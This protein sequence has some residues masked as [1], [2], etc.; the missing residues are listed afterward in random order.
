MHCALS[1]G[2]IEGED[3]QG[4]PWAKFLRDILQSIA[5]S[6]DRIT[7]ETSVAIHAPFHLS[8]RL[9]KRPG[10]RSRLPREGVERLRANSLL[11]AG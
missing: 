3:D 6:I 11:N 2:T 4:C 10:S 7:V 1:E 8:A 5:G 9:S